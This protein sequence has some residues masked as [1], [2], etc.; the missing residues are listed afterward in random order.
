VDAQQFPLGHGTDEIGFKR[1]VRA[2]LAAAKA[3]EPRPHRLRVV[4]LG[5][6]YAEK[7]HSSLSV[8]APC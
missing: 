7:P 1:A 8:M 4:W 5:G 2:V 6:C 3:K